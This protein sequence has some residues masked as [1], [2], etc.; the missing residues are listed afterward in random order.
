MT[1]ISD[2]GGVYAEYAEEHRGLMYIEPY[3]V[4][5]SADEIRAVFGLSEAEL[6]TDMLLQ[7]PYT[8]EVSD[9]LLSVDA[10]MRFLW[11][12]RQGDAGFVRAVESYALYCVANKLCDVLPLIAARTLT[13]SKSTF[14]R[15]DIDIQSVIARIRARY[16]QA[17]QALKDAI[18]ETRT[19]R[20]VLPS[21][22]GSGKPVYD[23]VLGR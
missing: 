5:T 8:N 7:K 4:L 21:L 15:F 16:A 10:D 20:M 22:F 2:I 23:P 18:A 1:G 11:L 6:P 13:D 14:Q 17:L 9:G 12:E 19:N 3:G